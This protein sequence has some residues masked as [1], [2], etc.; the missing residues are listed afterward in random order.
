MSKKRSFS[1]GILLPRYGEDIPTLFQA[2]E[3]YGASQVYAVGSTWSA[4]SLP[5]SKQR[6][7]RHYPPYSY[8]EYFEDFQAQ[9]LGDGRQLVL[10]DPSPTD[11]A[12]EPIEH[13]EH[14]DY[15]TYLFL[16]RDAALPK[17]MPADTLYVH[18]AGSERLSPGGS[19]AILMYDRTLR[20]EAR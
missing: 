7:E 5:F 4:N 10:V 18:V 9:H 20:L 2:A 8:Y 12:S 1:I 17:K 6:K 13:F 11:Q 14:P 19:G 3:A 16:G 15:A